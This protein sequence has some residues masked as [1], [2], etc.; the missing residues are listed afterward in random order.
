MKIGYPC[1]NNSIGCKSSR[2]FRLRNYSPEKLVEI[3]SGNLECLHRTLLFNIENSIFSFRITSDLVPFASHKVCSYNWGK[4]FREDFKR[5]GDLISKNKIRISMH[6]DQFVILNAQKEDIKFNSIR[7]LQYHASV[8]DLM[9]LDQ[10]AKIQIHVGGVYGD[11]KTSIERF[12]KVYKTLD[13][14]IKNRLVIENDEK[15]YKASDCLYI[16]SKTGIPVLFDY[17]HHR[18]NNNGEDTGELIKT[19][20]S[21]WKRKDGPAMMDY[22]SQLHGERRGRHAMKIDL[23]DFKKFLNIV[24]DSDADIMLEIKDKEK[25]A[26][27]AVKI[28]KKEKLI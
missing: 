9:G 6:P 27:E 23:T 14:K 12:I 15:S 25:S 8:M 28:L 4:H 24:K 21:T 26:I 19:I 10:K 11:K 18:L 5:L 2:T 16:S 17:F 7:E 22:S 13:N 20:V 3:V 1:I